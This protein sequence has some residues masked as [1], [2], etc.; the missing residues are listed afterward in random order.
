LGEIWFAEAPTPEGPWDN[1]VK[2]VTHDCGPSSSDYTFYNPALHPYFDQ[3]GGRFIYFEGT[4]T[5]SF[6]NNPNPT[7]RYE[8]NQMM[9]RLD[10]ATIQHL[11]QRLPGDFDH[12]GGVDGRD[13]L[14]WQ[15]GSSPNPLSATDLADWQA[16]YGT[17]GLIADLATAPEP[18]TIL[19]LLASTAGMLIRRHR[20]ESHVA[21][22]VR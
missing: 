13:F 9:Y 21:K 11:F 12:N 5:N 22:L 20:A 2:V 7:P 18:E 3:D 17:A 8:Y 10:L 1:A 4:Y 14:A 6:T 16:N 15:R 19:M